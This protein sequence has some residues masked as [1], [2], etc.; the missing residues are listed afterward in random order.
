MLLAL[1][2]VFRNRTY[3]M[4]D[5]ELS[6]AGLLAHTLSPLR[7]CYRSA[8]DEFSRPLSADIHIETVVF[9]FFFLPPPYKH[10]SAIL[11][12]SLVLFRLPHHQSVGSS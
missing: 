4:A 10:L 5:Q 2:G 3:L 12:D 7:F 6:A 8:T 11:L 9:S 1:K